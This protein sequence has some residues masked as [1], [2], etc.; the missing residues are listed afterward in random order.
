MIRLGVEQRRETLSAPIPVGRITPNDLLSAADAGYQL[1]FQDSPPAYVLTGSRPHYVLVVEEGAWNNPDF[2][3]VARSLGLSPR[4]TTYE[5]DPGGALSNA[6]G[7]R[8]QVAT[9]SVLGTMAY[10]SNA[11]SVPAVH[12]NQG[13]V[14]PAGE[15]AALLGDLLKVQVS[16][17]PV[18]DAYLSVPYRGFW[19]YVDDSD[20]A[21]KR[22]LGLLT[23]L[24]RLTIQA[25]GAQNVP[26]LTLPVTR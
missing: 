26:V 18:K 21:T 17:V 6:S 24:I 19:F 1:E 15:L 2:V 12:E 25:G 13:L 7:G 11:V 3:E 14:S 10:L 5:I 8:L 20:L 22:S 23:S 4:R 9:R 16:A